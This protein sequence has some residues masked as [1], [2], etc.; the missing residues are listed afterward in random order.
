MSMIGNFVAIDGATLNR[1]MGNPGEV[2]DFLYPEGGDGPPNALD[3]EK[4]W[5]AIHFTLN[6]SQW[7][8]H[9]ALGMVVLGGT[10]IGEDAG[11]GPAR[12]LLQGQVK[13]IAEAL[14]KISKEE[15]IERFHPEA[16]DAQKIYPQI[17]SRDGDFGRSYVL[18]HFVNLVN[19]YR[20]A[21]ERSDAML[22]FIN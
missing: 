11:Y 1:L 20:G 2:V 5:H 12:Y 8:G 7:E 9:G 21:A 10:E 14:L 6:G 3:V 19:F 16:M 17:W 4:A 15:F 22:L 18:G 13:E